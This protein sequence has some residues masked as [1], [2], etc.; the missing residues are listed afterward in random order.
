GE[1]HRR[2]ADRVPLA[3]AGRSA[4]DADRARAQQDA[5]DPRAGGYPF[6][7]RHGERDP[8]PGADRRGAWR[9]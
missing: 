9:V 1:D 3:P 4:P 7:A 2:Q 8:A 5:Q 6:G